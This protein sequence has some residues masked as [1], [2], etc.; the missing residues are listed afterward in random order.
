MQFVVFHA[1]AVNLHE[2]CKLLYL[3]LHWI[4]TCNDFFFNIQLEIERRNCGNQIVEE[5]EECDCGTSEEC[6]NDPC[7][8]SITCKLKT[9]AQCAA[10]MCCDMC[11]VS[12]MHLLKL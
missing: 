2:K 8:D 10:G 1:T 3:Y 12:F 9:E 11:K 4:K 6:L 5:D 7:C